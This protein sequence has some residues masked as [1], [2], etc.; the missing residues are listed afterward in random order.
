[1]AGG[2]RIPP[3]GRVLAVF[4]GSA[5]YFALA[6]WGRGGAAAF[7]S[8]PAL[9]ALAVVFWVMVAVSP[10][11][12]G[13]LSPGLREDRGNRWVLAVL[14]I[15]GLAL[16][17]LPAW[18]DRTNFF[19]LDG[20]ALRWFGVALFVFG[21]W[22]RLWPVAVLGD[23]FSGLVA[24]QPGHRLVTDGPYATIRHPSYLGLLLYSLGWA[25]AFRSGL[26]VL[27]VLLFIPP[28]VARIHSE[29][30]LLASEFGAE[31]EAYR[32]KTWRMIP[33][34]W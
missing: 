3:P 10:F 22:V 6:V 17:Y 27:I 33:G 32:R 16:G 13:N 20:D 30:R 12:G 19:T 8:H 31:Y 25:L 5:A 18:S 21:A 26:G 4:A 1:V 34:L 2:L 7:F 14:G 9:T 29:E 28:L 11:C 24:I 23:L 15:L